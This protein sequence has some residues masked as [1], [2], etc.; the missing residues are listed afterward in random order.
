MGYRYDDRPPKPEDHLLRLAV[1][2]G[3]MLR[4]AFG[5]YYL[6]HH[7]P[8]RHDHAGW[9]NPHRIDRICQAIGNAKLLKI[10]EDCA[11]LEEIDLPGEGYDSIA[12]EF[13]ES[14]AVQYFTERSAYFDD[15]E[16]NVVRIAVRPNLPD[17]TDKPVDVR[18]T[19]FISN[20]DTVDAVC[21]GM[22]TILPGPDARPNV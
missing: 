17:F 4:A 8:S 19:L 3:A 2:N 21:H 20:A 7:N 10:N 13:E 16:P 15:E 12:I 5:C 18:F 1:R 6:K 14:D 22:I 9:P 11:V